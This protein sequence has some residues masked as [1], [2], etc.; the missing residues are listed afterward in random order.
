[1]R[2]LAVLFFSFITFIILTTCTISCFSQKNYRHK[3]EDEIAAMTPSQRIDEFL[4][5]RY[6]HHPFDSLTPGQDQSILIKDYIRKD[7]TKALPAIANIA[8]R[9]HPENG[10]SFDAQDDKKAINF[11]GVLFLAEDIDNVVIRIRAS[12]EGRS[13]IKVFEAGLSRMKTAGWAVERHKW[14]RLYTAYSDKLRTM[15]G[16]RRSFTDGYIRDTL[17]LKHNIQMSDE[18]LVKF[19]NYLT[20]LDPNYPS[21]CKLKLSIC[22]NSKEYYEAYLKFKS[23]VTQ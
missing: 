6:Y 8:N 5:E 3:T 18:E 9:F 7:G 14:N 22:T 21:R 17:R 2:N 19:D 10:D 23:E 15:R 16:E 13:A 20:S 4:K 11:Q 12:E 1:M